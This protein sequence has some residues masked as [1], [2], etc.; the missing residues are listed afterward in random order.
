LPELTAA[1]FKFKVRDLV[2]NSSTSKEIKKATTQS[3]L[4]EVLAGRFL[5]ASLRRT[6]RCLLFQLVCLPLR[7]IGFCS[8]F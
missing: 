3:G 8:F 6:A 5:F 1:Q 4:A 2:S 7:F